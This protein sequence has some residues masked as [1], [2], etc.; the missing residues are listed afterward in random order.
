MLSV[1]AP[2]PFDHREAD[3]ILRSSDKEPVD[4]RTFKLLLSL[5]SPFFSELFTLP[6][7]GGLEIYTDESVGI[8]GVPV[9]QM[10]EDSETLSILLGF[11]FPVSLFEHPRFVTLDQVR[12]V[13]EAAVKLEMLSLQLHLKKEL[14]ADRFIESQPIRV[15][16][17]AFRYGWDD[18]ARKAARYT[19]RQSFSGSFVPELEY[20]SGATYFKLQEYHR[21]CGEVASARVLVQPALADVDDNWVWVTCRRCSG[22]S[23][24]S[25]GLFSD[26][27]QLIVGT[28]IPDTRRWW[29]QWIASVAAE[30]KKRPWGEVVRNWDLIKEAVSQAEACP[31]C[32]KKAR[33]DLEGFAQML[34]VDIEREISMVRF[35]HPLDP[36]WN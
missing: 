29:T 11:C 13:I 14:V 19:L 26:L 22:S 1:P 30:L 33:E 5:S 28:P 25:S 20:I 10:A 23:S 2:H 17:I 24:R 6:Q 12:K 7:S 16:A 27:A 18:E 31:V 34:A 36:F 32:H 3:V 8:R 21:V 4:F 9:V 15:F 35:Q